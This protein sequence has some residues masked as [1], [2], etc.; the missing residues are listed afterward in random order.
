MCPSVGWQ[1]VGVGQEH[2]LEPCHQKALVRH[3]VQHCLRLNVLD[4]GYKKVFSLG[5]KFPPP[6]PEPPPP[7]IRPPGQLPLPPA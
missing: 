2:L 5:L 4:M 1:L 7:T 3:L 6:R